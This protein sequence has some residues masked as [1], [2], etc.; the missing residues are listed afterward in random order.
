MWG[1]ARQAE[2]TD[3]YQMNYEGCKPFAEGNVIEDLK[4]YSN[5]T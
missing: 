4:L 5:L 2:D 1:K 3:R